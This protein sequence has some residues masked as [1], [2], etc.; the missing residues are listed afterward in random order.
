VYTKVPYTENVPIYETYTEQVEKT[1]Q[2]IAGYEPEK[3]VSVAKTR[4]KYKMV[5]TL[6]KCQRRDT[7]CYCDQRSWSQKWLC[8]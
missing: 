1:R 6:C 8:C 7:K 3:V 2:I 5:P 4:P